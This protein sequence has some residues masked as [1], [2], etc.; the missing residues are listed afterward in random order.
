MAHILTKHTCAHKLAH[1]SCFVIY[2][3]KIKSNNNTI[4]RLYHFSFVSNLRVAL[5]CNF[6]SMEKK[7]P[8]I[9]GSYI[10]QCRDLGSPA[11]QHFFESSDMVVQSSELP[12]LFLGAEKSNSPGAQGVIKVL[13]RAFLASPKIKSKSLVKS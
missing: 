3:D 6:W 9:T 4:I 7:M 2:F 1:S 11:D 12:F 8:W 10:P 13:L 5:H